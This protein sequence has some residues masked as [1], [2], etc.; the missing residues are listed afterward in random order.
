MKF[1]VPIA[2]LAV[3][4]VAA[5]AYFHSSPTVQP[6]NDVLA[7]ASYEARFGS[8]PSSTSLTG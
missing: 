6:V 5:A 1:L 8:L 2:S 4:L 7:D 3:L